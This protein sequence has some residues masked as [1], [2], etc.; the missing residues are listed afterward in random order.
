MLAQPAFAK[1]IASLLVIFDLDE[2]LIHAAERPLA[3]EPD[4][5]VG[6]FPVYKRPFVEELL[7]DC[8]RDCTLAVWT[9]ATR[10]YAEAVLDRLIPA[11]VSFAFVWTRERCTRRYMPE[12]Q[13]HGW[14]KDLK[15]VKKRGFP[16]ERVLMV[17]DTPG[18][19][20]RQYGNYI[21]V[22]PYLGDEDDREL[23]LLAR[24]LRELRGVENVRKIEKRGWQDAGLAVDSRRVSRKTGFTK[25]VHVLHIANDLARCVEQAIRTAQ[26]NGR[27]PAFDPAPV[28]VGRGN[29]PGAGDY[30]CPVALQLGGRLGIPPGHIAEAI[31]AH[32]PRPEYLSAVEQRQGYINFRLAE[33]WLQRQVDVILREGVTVAERDSRA[34]Q[35]IQVECISANPTGPLTVGRI[36]GGII[37]DT[38]ARLLRAQGHQVE[39]EYYYNNAGRQMQVLAESLRARY[40]E[41]LGLPSDL[42]RRWVS[43][44]VCPRHRG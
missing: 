14:I 23:V 13:D 30:A 1:T 2:T 34:G 27:L 12:E 44:G 31:L 19:L 9:S 24:Y 28:K 16:L 29:R 15:K 11:G 38:L 26:A 25:D 41:R 17:D 18:N 3:R 8:A 35:R 37:G 43:R 21:R 39:M 6:P 22:T 4:F 42:S 7:I 33:R 36:R 20:A 5:T 40:L 32:F 10:D